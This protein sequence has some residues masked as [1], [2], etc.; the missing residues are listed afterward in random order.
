MEQIRWRLG[1]NRNETH[2]TPYQNGTRIEEHQLT[3]LSLFALFPRANQTASTLCAL[4]REIATQTGRISSLRALRMALTS[5][6]HI[7]GTASGN[8]V[9]S[10]LSIV[11][12]SDWITTLL[13]FPPLCARH[14]IG[15]W[16]EQ[17]HGGRGIRWIGRHP[18]SDLPFVF[19]V[20][21]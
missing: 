21:C 8:F 5:C 2:P 9:C 1:A 18:H 19:L 12:L 4:S 7:T 20:L 16:K 6:L 17:R 14:E 3:S 10:P 11:Y 13:E 15:H